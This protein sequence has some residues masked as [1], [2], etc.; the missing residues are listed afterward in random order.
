MAQHGYPKQVRAT[1][2]ID[3]LVQLAALLALLII[4]TGCATLRTGTRDLGTY[5]LQIDGLHLSDGVSDTGLEAISMLDIGDQCSRSPEICAEQ[6][7]V[8]PGTVRT[9]TRILAAAEQFYQAAARSGSGRPEAGWLDCA[10]LTHRYLRATDLAGRRGPLE[11]RSQLALRIHNACTAGLLSGVT[12]YGGPGTASLRWDVDERVFPRTAVQRLVLADSVTVEGP[13]TRQYDDGLGVPAV[14]VGRTDHRLGAFPSQPFALP[15]NVRFEIG[16]TGPTLVVSDASRTRS[17]DT[18][19]G[20]V[21]LARDVTAAYALAAVEF[22]REESAWQSLRVGRPT[23]ETARLRILTPPDERKTPVV[24]IHGLASS[25]LTWVNIAN[26]LLGDPDI[27]EHFEIWLMR[28]STGLP[29]LVNRQ[30]IAQRLG[31]YQGS[32]N[33]N[34]VLIG[35]SMGGVLA[36]LLVTDSGDSLWRAAFL[37]EPDELR[38]TKDDIEAARA[39]FSFKPVPGIDEVVLIAAPHGGSPMA[40]GLLGRAARSL[41]GLP[42]RL[43]QPVVN[44]TRDNPERVRPELRSNYLAGGPKSLDTLSPAQPVIRAARALPVSQDVLVHS[45]IG[46]RDPTHPDRGDGVVPLDSA[47]WPAGDEQFIPGG[48]DLHAEP[49]TVLALKRILLK[50]LGRTHYLDGKDD[51]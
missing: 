43:L 16:Q 12:A 37:A 49:A 2:R 39:L 15:V 8:A 33:G 30:L 47:R 38:G 23:A 26:D 19:F 28:Y 6:L 18:A 29:L 51:S 11:A 48:H 31:E 20:P 4:L 41:I 14:A 27:S 42:P 9:G 24:L 17:V 44:L 22:E 46:I 36:R 45:I 21:R 5:P 40:D 25:P 7:L 1:A 10:Q 35:H 50:R 13:R 3:S 34:M 32:T